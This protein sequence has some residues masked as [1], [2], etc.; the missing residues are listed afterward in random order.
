MRR[1]YGQ[2]NDICISYAQILEKNV[3]KWHIFSLWNRGILQHAVNERKPFPSVYKALIKTQQEEQWFEL[4]NDKLKPKTAYYTLKKAAVATKNLFITSFYLHTTKIFRF[5]QL[6]FLT[7]Y[8][9]AVPI[10]WKYKVT[11]IC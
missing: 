3:N 9:I 7:S 4:K 11:T 1:N 10:I 8:I 2:N 5:Y 6:H